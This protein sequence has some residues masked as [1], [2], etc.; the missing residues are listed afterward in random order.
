MPVVLVTHDISEAQLLADRMV[1]I[2]R[3]RCIAQGSTA[4][5]MSDPAA[6]RG[7]GIREIA[8][9]LPASMSNGR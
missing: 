7:M 9:M 5:V 3:G 6:L 1:V 2:E 8:A 4:A